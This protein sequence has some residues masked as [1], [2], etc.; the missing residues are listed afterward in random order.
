M[1]SGKRIK[2]LMEVA[3]LYYEADETQSEIAKQYG[4]SRPMV[5]RLLFPPLHETF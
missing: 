5:S 2:R 4:I 1:D 3:S